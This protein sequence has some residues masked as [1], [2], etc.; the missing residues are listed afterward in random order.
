[1]TGPSPAPPLAVVA[2]P[3]GPVEYLRTGDGGPVT[4]VA[5][6][7]TGS[8]SETR[9]FGSGVRGVRVFVHLRGHG[10]TP[11]PVTTDGAADPG[12]YRDLAAELGAVVD[13]VGATRALGVSMGAGCVA[14]MLLDEVDGPRRLERA[15]LV[16]PASLDAPMPGAGA[17]RLRDLADAVEARD[18]ERAAVLLRDHQPAAVRALPAVR[19]WARRRSAELTGWPVAPVLRAVAGLA[20]MPDR[21]ALAAVDVPVLVVAQEDDEA[22]PVAV[23]RAYTEVLPKARLELLP[24]GAVPWRGRERLREVITEF[25]NG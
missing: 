8:I 15:V 12:D 10:G 5:H 3:A 20:P 14:R 18:V 22:H 17:Q 13:A 25:L 6:G 16:L 23:A 7:L 11:V 19:V 1:M 24:P 9:V 4:V 2:G 21:Q